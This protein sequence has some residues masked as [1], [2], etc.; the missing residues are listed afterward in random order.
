MN[1]YYYGF[2]R[3]NCDDGHLFNYFELN[4]KHISNNFDKLNK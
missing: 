3:I 4:F 1:D 2:A